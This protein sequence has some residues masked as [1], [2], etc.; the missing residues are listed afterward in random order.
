M[1][2]DVCEVSQYNNRIRRR[3]DVMRNCFVILIGLVVGIFIISTSFFNAPRHLD[4]N[5][6]SEPFSVDAFVSTFGQIVD[7]PLVSECMATHTCGKSCERDSCSIVCSDD[8][9]CFSGCAPSGHSWC[10]CENK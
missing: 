2:E 9:V 6:K 4:L 7:Q 8:Q 5:T 3:M 1:C 10:K